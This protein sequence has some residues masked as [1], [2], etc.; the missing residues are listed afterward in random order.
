MIYLA[1]PI[2]HPD[3]EVVKYRLTVA[4]QVAAR[5]HDAG[6]PVFSP[7]SHAAGFLPYSTQISPCTWDYWQRI[8]LPILRACCDMLAILCLDG[9]ETSEGVRAEIQSAH[10]IGIP[11]IFLVRCECCGHGLGAF[12][13]SGAPVVRPDISELLRDRLDHDNNK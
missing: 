11:V 2:K 12:A 13:S 9:W 5:L 6:V 3:P 10:E 1:V 7:A 8:D 4:S